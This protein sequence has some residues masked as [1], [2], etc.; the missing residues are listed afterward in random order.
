MV[1]TIIKLVL[2][3][4][5]IGAVGVGVAAVVPS[6]STCTTDVAPGSASD[7]QA[8]W[9]GSANGSAASVTFTE[10]DATAVLRSHLGKDTPLADPVVHFCADG[11]AQV[12]FGIKAGPVTLHSVADG[13]ISPTSPLSVKVTAIRVG[14]LPTAISDPVVNAVKGVATDAG[15][16]GLAGPVKSVTVTKGQAV[17]AK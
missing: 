17:V 8:K 1:G 2:G 7:A 5:V 4:V 12:S 14:A 3:V 11:T 10:A 6:P 16:L 9:D 13:T 15:S